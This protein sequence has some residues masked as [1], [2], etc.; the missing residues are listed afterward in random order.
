MNK[1]KSIHISGMKYKIKYDLA[2]PEAYGLTDPDTNTIYIRPDIPEDKM[3]RVFVHEITH[4]VVFETPFSTRKRFDLEEMCDIVGYH[5]LNA[6]RD[7][8]EI[9]Q[10]IL[11]EIE[12]E[13]E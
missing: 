1:P 12:D 9:V 13:A 7:N 6:L 10:Y 3:I 11:R 5:F 2:D 4:A 8:P